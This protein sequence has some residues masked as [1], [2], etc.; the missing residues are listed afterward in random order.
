MD[1]N[2]KIKILT[3]V[4][5][6]GKGGTERAS[7]NFALGYADLG[8]DS[9]V[10]VTRLDGP[11]RKR[12]EDNKL[13][14]LFLTSY[15]DLQSVKI[16]QPNVIHLHSHGITQDEFKTIKSLVPD[17]IY[18]ETNVFSIP[19]PW[20][21][22]LDY[23]FQLSDW[24]HWRYSKRVAQ[25]KQ[26]F[27]VPNPVICSDFFVDNEDKKNL[28]SNLRGHLGLGENTFIIGRV[29]QAHPAN[30]S[31][32]MIEI[33][34]AVHVAGLKPYL[35]LVSPPDNI[36]ISAKKSR[37]R[38]FIIVQ[39]PTNDDQILRQYYAGFDVFLHCASAG[40]TFGYVN[41][42]AI[43]SRTAVLTMATPWGGGNSQMEVVN[44]GLSGFVFHRSQT[45][46]NI[47]IGLL[48]GNRTLN[49]QEAIM[50]I[51]NRFDHRA[52]AL[53]AVNIISNST[54]CLEHPVKN[55]LFLLKQS[56][57]APSFLTLIFIFLGIPQLTRYSSGFEPWHR[58]LFRLISKLFR[59]SQ[60]KK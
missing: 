46:V 29:G 53:N 15:E 16:W 41:A 52:V 35:L 51:C 59:I 25:T 9:R 30:W 3:V 22:E 55:P 2:K 12:I 28:R 48:L 5:S 44:N 56:E 39:P 43:L 45:A 42:E 21:K 1:V 31:T 54:G 18:V 24:C 13:P 26:A 10:M 49:S 6:L 20:N 33:F 8:H 36:K 40:E 37:F 58:L 17:A 38:D 4:Y 19:S 27:V 14:L 32:R 47:L 7:Q 34:E 60:I 50:D 57:D 11:R 23:S